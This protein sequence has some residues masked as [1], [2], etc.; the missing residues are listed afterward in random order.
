MV[1]KNINAY[2]SI[3]GAGYHVCN[4]CLEQKTIRPWRTVTDSIDHYKIYLAIHGYTLSK[5]KEKTKTDL[6]NCNLK[7]LETF[8]PEIKDVIK[9]IMSEPI[10]RKKLVTKE[11][12]DTVSDIENKDIAI[13]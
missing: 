1:E 8:K 5:D 11:Q 12:K 10:R 3:C 13:L 6:Q 4:S 9:E 7:D 2:C